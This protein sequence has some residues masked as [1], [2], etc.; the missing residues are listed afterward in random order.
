MASKREQGVQHIKALKIGERISVRG[1]AHDLGISE[2]TAYQAIKTAETR[3]YVSTIERVGTVRVDPMPPAQLETLNYHA[4]IQIINGVILGGEA[5]LNKVLHRFLIG[6]MTG[7]RMV[8]YITKDSLLIVGN[9]EE[10]QRLALENGAAVLITGGLGASPEIIE[11]ANQKALPVLMTPFDTYTVA[12]LIN[13]ALADQAIKHK[14]ATVA[15]IYIPLAQTKYLY[16]RQTVADYKRLNRNT[17]HSRFPVITQ[18]QQLVGVVTSKDIFDYSGQTTLDKVMTA[19]PAT[20]N[21]TT[22][23]ASVSHMM[24]YDGYELIPV[25]DSRLHLLGI[26]S[27]Q[28]VMA[29][30][31]SHREP[32]QLND[33]FY[34][35]VVSN[36]KETIGGVYQLVVSPQMINQLGTISFGVLSELVVNA[37]QRLLVT[38][39]NR[40]ST[41]DQVDLHYLR[42]IQ[43]DT[44]LTITPVIMESGRHSAKLDVNVQQAGGLVAKAIVVCQLLEGHRGK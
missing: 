22:S 9:R 12:S 19:T 16:S 8:P 42:L 31:D 10:I 5:G 35:Q 32:V 14:I 28:D 3:G 38:K 2:G 21:E 4:L 33:T 27:R 23:L 41:I 44:E 1:L 6:A 11:L 17:D 24:V 34:D 18:R 39:M 15:D 37:C 40:P 7:D 36:L 20:V 43:L 30:L 29:T 26:I 13:R 25:V